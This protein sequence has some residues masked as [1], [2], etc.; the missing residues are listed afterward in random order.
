MQ[1][2]MK[3]GV[4]GATGRVGHHAVEVLRERGHDVMPMAR[5]LGVDVATGEGLAEA[6]KGVD[7]VIDA[8]S[9]HSPDQDAATQFFLDATRNLQ[10]MGRQAGVKGLVVVSI[11]GIEHF[12]GGY[13]A[14]KQAQERAMLEGPLPVRLLRAAQFHEFVAPLVDWGRKGDR[15]FVQK[16]RTQLVSARTVAEALVDLATDPAFGETPLNAPILEIAGPRVERL[17]DVARLLVAHR[18][19]PVQVEEAPDTALSGAGD[20]DKALYESG[21][22]LP[23]PHAMLAGP[24]FREWVA[25]GERQP[26][27][28]V[29]TEGA[30]I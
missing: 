24:T 29:H 20:P 16:M 15:S 18:G 28:L 27:S 2:K 25:A 13:Y 21:A 30:R 7:Y 17:V 26:G 19:D 11:I 8:A 3:V 5:S 22:L 6:L 4:V 14:A 9:W 10:T 1:A 23:S 12:S